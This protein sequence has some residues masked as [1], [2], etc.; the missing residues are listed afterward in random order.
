MKFISLF[1][2][3][4]GYNVFLI[5]VAQYLAAIFILA[6]DIPAIHTITDFNLFCIVVASS[7]TIASGY[8]INNF[9]DSQKDL[10]NRPKKSM[11]DRLVSQKTKLTTYFSINFIVVIFAW[12]VSWRAAL[13]FSAYI[14]LVWIYSHKIKK[15]TIL[16]N[17]MSSLLAI[18]PFFAIFLMYYKSIINHST[19]IVI[20][21]HATF[22]FILLLI[23]ELTKDLRNII[24]DFSN[25]YLTIPVV[26]GEDTSKKFITYLSIFTIIP[27]YV[28]I[29]LDDV[30]YMDIYFYLC[31]L[32]LIAFNIKLWKSNSK[33]QYT[34]LL[35][36]LKAIIAAGVICIV[37]I[38]PEV[39][40]HGRQYLLNLQ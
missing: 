27:V 40:I 20:F 12:L 9:Y 10:I 17:V 5:A 36:S 19:Y 13:F 15:F 1:S 38:D 7:L 11:L 18:L 32:F 33:K 23:K 4:R 6:K 34:K 24:G 2:V 31:L 16:G 21:A 37:L 29:E 25:N 35:I 8:I 26:Y 30:G 14:F 39:L 3:V 28:L 22:L